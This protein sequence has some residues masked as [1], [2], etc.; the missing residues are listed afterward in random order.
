MTVIG[1]NDPK[2]DLSRFSPMDHLL[3][4]DYDPIFIGIN[5]EIVVYCSSGDAEGSIIEPSAIK[6]CASGGA[7]QRRDPD[8]R[9][10]QSCHVSDGTDKDDSRPAVLHRSR[11]GPVA[12]Q[13]N[14][15]I[16]S[17]IRQQHLTMPLSLKQG[18][19]DHWSIRQIHGE[20]GSAEPSQAAIML[21][22]QWQYSSHFA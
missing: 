9:V 13:C 3:I 11:S 17:R 6:G 14:G 22:R 21:E 4:G 16:A 12:D 2:C 20:D 19:H 10:T 18:T 7:S 5:P 15:T 8:R 1:Q